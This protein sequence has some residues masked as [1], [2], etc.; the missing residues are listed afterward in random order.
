MPIIHIHGDADDVVGYSGVAGVLNAWRTHNGCPSTAQTTKPYPANKSGSPCTKQY[1]GPCTNSAIMLLTNAGKGHWYTMDAAGINSSEEI[2][3]FCKNYSLNQTSINPTSNIKPSL[4]AV[5]VICENSILN[6][7]F[8]KAISVNSISLFNLNGD[9]VKAMVLPTSASSHNFDLSD[10]P[11][12]LYLVKISS[13][14]HTLYV[15]N[16]TY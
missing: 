4:S 14:K 9:L 10:L 7:Q 15:Q 3:A 2:W 16:N 8:T 5:K 11:G 12:G 13:E 6:V 1:W